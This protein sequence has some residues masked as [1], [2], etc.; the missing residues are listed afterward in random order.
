[1]MPIQVS[2][3]PSVFSLATLLSVPVSFCPCFSFTDTFSNVRPDPTL[4]LLHLFF[5][6]H[7]LATLAPVLAYLNLL[8]FFLLCTV[9]F[10]CLCECTLARAHTHTHTHSNKQPRVLVRNSVREQ[11]SDSNKARTGNHSS[12]IKHDDVTVGHWECLN[13]QPHLCCKRI[14]LYILSQKD[15]VSSFTII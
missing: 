11:V 10:V 15:N 6:T 12:Q 5:L 7:F 2:V 13:Q 3:I 8:S 9:I 14:V 4:L 1:M